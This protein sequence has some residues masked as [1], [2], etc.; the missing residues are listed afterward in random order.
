[1][2]TAKNYLRLFFILLFLLGTLYI[3]YVESE[4]Y[5]SESIVLLKDLSK[6]QQMNLSELLMGQTNSTMQDSKVLELYMR[7]LEMFDD[8]DG[9]FNLSSYYRS[10]ALD[11]M[12]R[13]YSDAFLPIYRATQ[14]NILQ[15]Y[16][17]DLQITYDDPSGALTLSFVHTD[18]ATAQ[19]ILQRIL[20]KAEEVV[21]HFAKENAQIALD[22]IQKQREQKRQA[23]VDA[24]K[25]LIEYQNAHHTIDPS[26]DVE[27]QIAIL[28][29]LETELIK[30]EVE[31][32]TKRKTFNPNSREIIMLKENIQNLRASISKVKQ[33]LAGNSTNSE[34]NTNV[35]AF[36]LLKNDMEFAKEVYKRTLISREEL[37][38]EVAQKSKHLIIIAKP[39]LPDD[40]TYPN[41]LWDIFTLFVVLFILYSVSV[42]VVNIIANHK[43]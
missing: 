33:K 3:A 14:K 20:Q 12:Q 40:Y 2:F 1:M 42:S 35:F 26:M 21:N 43:D 36:Q 16:N 38:A 34:L 15:Q 29:E 30:Q 32:A 9:E 11:F 39:T 8:I 19:Q 31:Y 41:K 27:R 24:I 18:P 25:K 13:Y 37:L 5:E 23:F 7:S 10:D 28:T 22:F 17:K 6:K 4:R